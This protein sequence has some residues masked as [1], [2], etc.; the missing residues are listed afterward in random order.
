MPLWFD[1]LKLTVDFTSEDNPDAF[2][3]YLG[4]LGRDEA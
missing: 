3:A 2:G 1:I 4:N